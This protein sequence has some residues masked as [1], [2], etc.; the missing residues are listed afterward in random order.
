MHYDS[1]IKY[2]LQ[3]NKNLCYTCDDEHEKHNQI[4]LSEIKPNMNEINNNLDQ[5][6]KEI[7]IFNNNIKEIIN[8]LNDLADIMH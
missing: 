4:L 1:F 8:K 6:K 2:C 7:D 5:M 3:C